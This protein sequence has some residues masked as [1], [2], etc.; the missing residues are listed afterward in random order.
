MRVRTVAITAAVLITGLLNGS[1]LA[2]SNCQHIKGRAY[3]S[4]DNVNTTSGTVTN[5]GWL[6]GTYAAVFN[7]AGFP[8]PHPT[9]V[10]FT[11]DYTIQTAHGELKADVLYL[12]DFAAGVGVNIGRIKPTTS[13]GIFAGATG[14]LNSIAKVVTFTPYV[15]EEEIT[16]QICFALQ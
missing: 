6:N 11:S 12:Y 5:A 15:I 2:Q 13:T 14:L 1:A 8:T 10:T 3:G 7:S 16:G 4:F 9:T